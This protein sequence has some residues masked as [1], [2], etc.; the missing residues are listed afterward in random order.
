ME[1]L[2]N[3]VE[4]RAHDEADHEI[5]AVEDPVAQAPQERGLKRPLG[6]IEQ[7]GVD[8]LSDLRRRRGEI[9]AAVW[10]QMPPRGSG[11]SPS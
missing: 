3:Q 2:V 5:D 6:A 1:R 11:T 7:L 9:V 4:S 8:G 10:D